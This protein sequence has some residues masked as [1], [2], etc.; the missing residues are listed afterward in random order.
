M[1]FAMAEGNHLTSTHAKLGV[2][3]AALA[4]TQAAGGALRPGHHHP[5]RGAWSLV[6]R[7]AGGALGAL[8]LPTCVLGGGLLDRKLERLQQPAGWMPATLALCGL[9][10]AVALGLEARRALS[11]CRAAPPPPGGTPAAIAP[12][13]SEKGGAQTHSDDAQ[14][15][16]AANGG[17]GGGGG[18][19]AK[20]KGGA[21]ELTLRKENGATVVGVELGEALH[22]G[23]WLVQMA[24]D[25]AGYRAGLRPGDILLAVDG[26]R[27]ESEEQAAEL[28]RAAGPGDHALSVLREARP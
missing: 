27:C 18:A 26:V 11:R 10:A 1:A 23:V 9:W 24:K 21:L 6:H 2:V 8:A 28:L 20:R 15:G 12:E 13:G 17:G 19:A 14:K 7:C 22:G 5:R 25:G 4:L 3:V 16:G